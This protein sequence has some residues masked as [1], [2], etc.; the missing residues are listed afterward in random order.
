MK[1]DIILEIKNIIQSEKLN[2]DTTLNDQQII[3]EFEDKVDWEGISEYQKLSED[4]IR[5]FKDNVY[6]NLISEYQKLSENFIREFKDKVD[7]YRISKYQK[8][9]ENFIREFQEKVDWYWISKYQK[10]SENFIREFQ[11]QVDWFR[12]S[13]FQKLSEEFIREFK[14]KIPENNMLYFSREQKL[15]ILNDGEDNPYEMEGDYI[16]AYKS[17]R[18]DGYSAYNFQHQ[19]KVGEVYESHADGNLDNEN[20][21]GLSA[22]TKE[23]ALEY[24]NDGELYKVR[25]HI[26]D[27][28][29][30]VH[31][32]KKL[33]CTKI[34]ILENVTF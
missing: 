1:I 5:E 8:L 33:R 10:L 23:G 2:I 9:S 26:D 17:T 22:W 15:K 3:L 27:V 20:S 30:I 28:S 19:Y 11:D 7:W 24:K 31:E 13:K 12:I 29:A 6:W 34:E 14:L 25:V 4:F 16:F 21:F 32:K 18:Q